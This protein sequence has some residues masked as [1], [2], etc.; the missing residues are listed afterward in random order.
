M[1]CS[2]DTSETLGMTKFGDNAAL[3][4][5]VSQ[6]VFLGGNSR[7]GESRKKELA[8]GVRTGNPSKK[9]VK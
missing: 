6:K 5:F 2:D 7:C 9:T 1:G 8:N 4:G 3:R